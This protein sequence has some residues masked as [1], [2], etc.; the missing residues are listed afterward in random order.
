MGVISELITTFSRQKIFGY[1]AIALSSIAIALISFLV[2]G[3]HMF[4]SGQSEVAAIIFSAITYL[5]GVPTGIKVIS[6][7]ATMYRG[8][9]SLRAPMIY[10]LMFLF[11]F[12]IGGLTG[13]M[14]GALNVDLHLHDTYYV[15]AH[16]HYVMMGGTV[17]AFIGGLHYW[18][19]KMTGRMYN[20]TL[21][22]VASGF[23]FIGFNVTFFTQFI[24]GSQGMPRRYYDYMPEY[25]QL[26]AFSTYGSFILGFGLLLV[27]ICFLSS[28]KNG[29]RVGADPWGGSTL[30]WLTTSP[31]DPHNFHNVPIV[32]QKPYDYSRLYDHMFTGDGV[33]DGAVAEPV[34]KPSE[35]KS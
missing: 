6:W 16:F 8:S 11:L 4:T 14:L 34:V 30:E 12:T 32:T 2:W 10:A 22:K 9:I 31:P 33:G 23:V 15:V 3:H 13:I 25:A 19:P 5:V 28:L 27:L 26:H 29:K 35:D 18:W 21:A 17:I 24:L 1:T 20:E 7:V